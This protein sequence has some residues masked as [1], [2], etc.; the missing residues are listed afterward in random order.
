MSHSRS[1]AL[2]WHFSVYTGRILKPADLPVAQSIKCELL[3]NPE[4]ARMLGLTVP[5]T[6]I[7]AGYEVI[8]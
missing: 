1:R 8:K 2:A 3:I 5:Q 4:T 6:L 7:V